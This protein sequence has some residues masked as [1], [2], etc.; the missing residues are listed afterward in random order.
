MERRAYERYPVHLEVKLKRLDGTDDDIEGTVIDVSFGGVGIITNG[1]LQSGAHISIEWVNPQFYY[2][3]EPVAVGA[4]VDVAK[5]EKE[6]KQFR[7]AVQFLEQDSG[8]IQSLLNWIRMQ[9]NMQM[10]SQANVKRFAGQ[11]KRVRF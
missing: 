4:I 9:A 8:L 3:G 6:G 7:L 1:E 5:P 10:R 11:Q 2:D